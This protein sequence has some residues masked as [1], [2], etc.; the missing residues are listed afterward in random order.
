MAKTERSGLEQAKLEAAPLSLRAPD[1][2][3]IQ[4]DRKSHKNPPKLGITETNLGDF[5]DFM[6]R[7]GCND[8]Y[9]LKEI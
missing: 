2:S 1:Y 4:S 5:I 7:S 6:P 8:V 3:A 9:I